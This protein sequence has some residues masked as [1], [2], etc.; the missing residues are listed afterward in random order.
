MGS[1]IQ[2]C[3]R[4]ATLSTLTSPSIWMWVPLAFV[5][6][7]PVLVTVSVLLQGYHGDTSRMFYVGS[8]SPEAKAL[9]ETTCAA[10]HKGIEACGP[11]VPIN[12]IGRVGIFT[13]LFASTL[14]F[15]M[16]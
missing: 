10:M 8:V 7:V 4:M 13:R 14:A 16:P 15:Q 1:P 6:F 11:G 12:A 3:W 5:Y 2:G 9:C